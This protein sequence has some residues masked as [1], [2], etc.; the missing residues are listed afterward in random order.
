M[1]CACNRMDRLGERFWCKAQLSLTTTLG[2]PPQHWV[3]FTH[4]ALTS[5]QLT[6]YANASIMIR[7]VTKL[8]VSGIGSRYLRPTLCT[9]GNLATDRGLAYRLKLVRKK[10]QDLSNTHDDGRGDACQVVHVPFGYLPDTLGGTEIYV[11]GLVKELSQ[12]GVSSVVVA[13]GQSAEYVHD[14]TRVLRIPPSP[15]LS[16]EALYGEGDKGAAARFGTALDSVKPQI[17]HFH[18]FTS[19]ASLLAMK[20]CARRCLPTLM[21]YH[22]PTVT[23]LRGTMLHWGKTPCDGVMVVTRCAS[24]ALQGRGLPKWLAIAAA[25]IPLPLSNFFA[26]A[27]RSRATTVLGIRWLTAIRHRAVRSAFDLCEYVVSPCDW[28]SEVLMR[29]GVPTTKIVLS[30]QGLSR[31]ESRTSAEPTAPSLN[32]T[33]DAQERAGANA[34]LKLIFLGRI[35]PTKGLH[36]LLRALAMRPALAVSLSIYSAKNTGDAYFDEISALVARDTRVTLKAALAN[37][38]VVATMRDYDLVVVPS[39]W[40]ETGP[41]VIY[42]AFAAGLPVLGSDLGGVAELVSDGRNGRLLPCGDASAWA[43]AIGE[44]A[45]NR[46]LIKNWQQNLPP[47]RT[48]R[49]VAQDMRTVYDNSLNAQPRPLGL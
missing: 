35:H 6:G 49:E 19:G 47:L 7:R 1:N 14:A 29:N 26:K 18:A 15:E 34:A 3:A 9:R 31:S 39:E 46:G 33:G 21:T 44:I 17:V 45:D 41:L 42:E 13:P 5:I 48:M 8:A 43:N 40:L 11:A 23:C 30:R 32:V 4:T 38:N 25:H 12:L 10:V 36:T 24:C 16:Q 22:T 37:A 27:L 2:Q 28:V 20:E